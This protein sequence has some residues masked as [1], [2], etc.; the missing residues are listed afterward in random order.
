ML[1]TARGASGSGDALPRIVKASHA[2]MA[3][4]MARGATIEDIARHSGLSKRSCERY[5]HSA[6]LRMVIGDLQ[7]RHY[8]DKLDDSS[9]LLEAAL[10]SALETLVS[11]ARSGNISAA[12]EVVRLAS[13]SSSSSRATS[14]IE[15]LIGDYTN[16]SIT[17]TLL[18]SNINTIPPATSGKA[19][20]HPSPEPEY[21]RSIEPM[22]TTQPVKEDEDTK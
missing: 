22:W 9:A 15:T 12:K 14:A 4:A 21:L 13:S 20:E 8:D 1:R 11:A 19:E 3:L 5:A 18:T 10:P 6:A 17:P 7:R 2:K 16:A